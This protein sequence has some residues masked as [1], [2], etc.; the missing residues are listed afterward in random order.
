[1]VGVHTSEAQKRARLYGL[2]LCFL[3]LVFFSAVKLA[4]YHSGQRDFAATKVWQ[5]DT[6]E[7][8]PIPMQQQTT[9]ESLVVMVLMFAPLA[10]AR[11]VPSREVAAVA[12]QKHWLDPSLFR[13]PPPVVR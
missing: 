5:Q 8:Q 10:V 11:M 7:R 13:R 3:L 4:R 12:P 9:V 6:S 2:A 1:M